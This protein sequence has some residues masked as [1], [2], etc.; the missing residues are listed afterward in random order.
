M[1]ANFLYASMPVL[2]YVVVIDGMVICCGVVLLFFCCLDYL[3]LVCYVPGQLAWLVATK[4]I[5]SGILVIIII[6]KKI[7][8]LTGK[9]YYQVSITEQITL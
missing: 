2:L 3:V 6:T 9:Y 1:F 5:I 4:G 8:R 7:I